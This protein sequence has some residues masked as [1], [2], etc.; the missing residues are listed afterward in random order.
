MKR[1][2]VALVGVLA[3]TVS[4]F[5]AVTAEDASAADGAATEIVPDA[6]T[7]LLDHFNGS[8]LGAAIGPLSY[9]ASISGL[10]QAGQFGPGVFV[11]YSFPAWYS[12]CCGSD[13]STQG[14][15]EAWLK[16]ST[17][18]GFLNFNWNDSTSVPSA[19]HVLY[20]VGPDP[21][22]GIFFYQ[23]WNFERGSLT[24]GFAGTSVIP[25]GK[26]VEPGIAKPE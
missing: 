7:V 20:G 18:G 12:Y 16:P 19:G 24:S 4:G 17:W 13:L 14:T 26:T 2:V 10:G 11:K 21:A 1:T 9:D 25:T 23:T 8:T 15:V 6:N 22:T 3:L 5:L